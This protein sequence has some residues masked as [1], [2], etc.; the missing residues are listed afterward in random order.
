ME[1]ESALQDK[2]ILNL[3]AREFF[4]RVLSSLMV[5][6]LFSGG[7][8]AQADS[9]LAVP[10]ALYPLINVA[11][12]QLPAEEFMNAIE[13]NPQ[14]QRSAILKRGGKEGQKLLNLVAKTDAE[15]TPKTDD[16]FEINFDAEQAKKTIFF[17]DYGRAVFKLKGYSFD[18]SLV[19]FA[20]DCNALGS[21]ELL[22][23]KILELTQNPES[24]QVIPLFT[25]MCSGSTP[26]TR[27]KFLPPNLIRACTQIMSEAGFKVALCEG[28][29][30]LRSNVC[31]S[32]RTSKYCTETRNFFYPEFDCNKK[33]VEE[34][35]IPNMSKRVEAKLAG[36][37]KAVADW[38]INI[39]ET[40]ADQEAAY[41]AGKEALIK[42][43]ETCPDAMLRYTSSERYE[44]FVMMFSVQCNF[45]VSYEKSGKVTYPDALL[46]RQEEKC[47][48]D[49]NPMADAVGEKI[50]CFNGTTEK[51]AR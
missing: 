39:L 16:R 18:E 2:S 43:Q 50:K 8:L 22:I 46:A 38:I 51:W 5:F 21:C 25:M 37:P 48:S 47:K 14:K 44:S 28:S 27:K 32:T 13:T 23:R 40:K 7:A 29:V 41:L 15:N 36:K 11:R 45:Q 10:Y 24:F 4:M 42:A 6:I 1:F 33:V 17:R 20:D 34:A 49:P 3:H 30:A 31:N 12:L 19:A 26:D 9:L 35:P